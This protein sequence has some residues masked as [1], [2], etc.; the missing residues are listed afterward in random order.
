MRLAPR[1][2]EGTC[3][4]LR[5]A[6]RRDRIL[7]PAWT[8][9]LALAAVA[10]AQAVNGLYSTLDSRVEAADAVNA[11]AALVAMFGRIYDPA[12]LG[13]IAMVKMTAF[14]GAGVA[15]IAGMITVR[16]S[17]TEEETG[18]LELLG[19]AVVGR[20][21][22]L[23]A[24]LG[25]AAITSVLIGAVTALG[26]VASGLPASGSLAFGAAWAGA[27]LAFAGVGAV[28]AQLA[29]TSRGATG[30][31]VGVLGLAY[32]M[33]GIGDTSAQLSWLS[34][35][36]PL[37]WVH[38]V[39]A[40]AGNRWPVLAPLVGFAGVMALVADAIAARRDLGAGVLADRPG[41]ARAQGWLSSTV[42]LAWRLER[43][44]LIA[45]VIAFAI[46]GL[47]VGGVAGDVGSFLNTSSGQD[48]LRRLGGEKSLV[49]AYL[50][51][52]LGIL[53]VVIAAYGVHAALRLRTEEDSRRAEEVL[54]TGV[55][56]V[57]WVSSFIL[58][59]AAGTVCLALAVGLSSGA[60]RA[61]QTGQVSDLFDLLA[62]ALVQLP[63]VW[64]VIAVVAAA[65]G[66]GSRAALIGW[67]ALVAFL[68]LGE[69]GPLLELPEW[70]IELSPFAHVPELPG[71]TLTVAPLVVLLGLAAA[72]LLAG[73]AGF[74]RRDLA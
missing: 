13:A 60:A 20:R 70:I 3:S 37:G 2:T 56:R 23:S 18:R 36:T 64:L 53:G 24:A 65:Y 55:T 59:A 69:I 6:L 43:G 48:V 62:G 7:V 11:S 1:G 33:R 51:A 4:L 27:G 40:F 16:H 72:L 9:V 39:R 12:S 38:S 66:I 45:W 10:S 29:R 61:V 46:L 19:G 25:I 17:R 71:T 68:L 26:L 14:G 15:M 42:G 63:A 73:L 35:L 58:V 8:L 57:Q 49:D 5:L 52:E 74:R 28:A 41:P 54:A 22:A 31:T 67:G 34:W 50:A 44:A 47:V 21:A 30:L 32:V